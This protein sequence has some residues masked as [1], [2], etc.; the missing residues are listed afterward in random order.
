[1]AAVVVVAV[2]VAVAVVVAAMA[3]NPKQNKQVQL[4][5]SGVAVTIVVTV[6][7]LL[8]PFMN[9]AVRKGIAGVGASSRGSAFMSVD[10]V[11]FQAAEDSTVRQCGHPCNVTTRCNMAACAMWP[12]I[13]QRS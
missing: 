3:P 12:P 2:A 8:V 10:S 9:A 7:A 5:K 11:F 1:M 13:A 4:A 6:Q